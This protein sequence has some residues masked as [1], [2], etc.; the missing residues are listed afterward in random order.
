MILQ[1]AKLSAHH[2]SASQ[3]TN[4][5]LNFHRYILASGLENSDEKML[6]TNF[7]SNY[8]FFDP[9]TLFS[10][11]SHAH[12]IEIPNCKPDNSAAWLSKLLNGEFSGILKMFRSQR[13]ST[14]PQKV[15]HANDQDLE[16][17]DT[18]QF[19]RPYLLHQHIN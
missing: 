17:F 18:R 19:T 5:I 3:P 13:R 8:E 14:P 2:Q 1:L 7:P 12:K 16:Q 4:N 10:F 9:E 6:A 15:F 11:N